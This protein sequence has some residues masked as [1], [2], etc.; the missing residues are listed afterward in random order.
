MPHNEAICCAHGSILYFFC[1]DSYLPALGP[2]LLI[3][4]G[5]TISWAILLTTKCFLITSYI[6]TNLI[7]MAP[8]PTYVLNIIILTGDSADRQDRTSTLQANHYVKRDE[9]M[10]ASLISTASIVYIALAGTVC[11]LMTLA[12][13]IGRVCRKKTATRRTSRISLPQFPAGQPSISGNAS[14]A[15]YN[16]PVTTER[17]RVLQVPELAAVSSAII[18]Q[19]TAATSEEGNERPP[20]YTVAEERQSG[21]QTRRARLQIPAEQQRAH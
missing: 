11:L 10:A 5:I 12:L 19:P 18:G 9:K 3:F 8:L 20:P 2:H 13:C 15:G 16:G 6:H 7:A 21:S 14:E 1:R 4:L 17:I